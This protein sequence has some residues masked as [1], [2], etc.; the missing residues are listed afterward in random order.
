MPEAPV[1]RARRAAAPPG[2][3]LAAAAW[4]RRIAFCRFPWRAFASFLAGDRDATRR[5]HRA[6]SRL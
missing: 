5:P 1:G 2:R 6:D 4:R 3:H